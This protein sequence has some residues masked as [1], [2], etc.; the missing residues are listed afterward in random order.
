MAGG[1]RDQAAAD[2]AAAAPV[3]GRPLQ[4]GERYHRPR[5]RQRSG[6]GTR[7]LMGDGDLSGAD[8]GVRAAVGTRVVELELH[9]GVR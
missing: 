5:S 1:N 3:V 8:D 6:P 2:C 4:V 7:G 9:C